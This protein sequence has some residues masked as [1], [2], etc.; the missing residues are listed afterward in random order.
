MIMLGQVLGSLAH[1]YSRFRNFI[2]SVL[3][4]TL[5]RYFR[6]RPRR[7]HQNHR[8][9]N[10]VLVIGI[11]FVVVSAHLIFLR[12]ASTILIEREAGIFGDINSWHATPLLNQSRVA[13]MTDFAQTK[14]SFF[15]LSK[16]TVLS[17][18][19]SFIIWEFALALHYKLHTKTHH[20]PADEFFDQHAISGVRIGLFGQQMIDLHSSIRTTGVGHQLRLD[21][22][23]FSIHGAL[24]CGLEFAGSFFPQRG[25]NMPPPTETHKETLCLHMAH[26]S[27]HHNFAQGALLGG[28]MQIATAAQRNSTLQ[29]STSGSQDSRIN[30]AFALTGRSTAHVMARHCPTRNVDAPRPWLQMSSFG[31]A[32]N[33]LTLLRVWEELLLSYDALSRSLQNRSSQ[34]RARESQL[35]LFSLSLQL[36]LSLQTLGSESAIL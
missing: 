9:W 23:E 22:G 31:T 34:N 27:A 3:L 6:W 11:V 18:A 19:S 13:A 35:V 15:G 32:M 28:T 16:D 7:P 14:A 36:A 30:M 8:A 12:D 26:S 1:D 2:F 10:I 17:E 33:Q 4:V 20:S 21:L 25:N 24:R 29:T 5:L